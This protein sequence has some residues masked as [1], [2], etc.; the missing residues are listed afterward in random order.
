[1]ILIGSK[2]AGLRNPKLAR[3]TRDF[4][5]IVSSFSEAREWLLMHSNLLR[6]ESNQS[7]QEKTAG[8]HSGH[9]GWC[10]KSD[11]DV[12]FEFINGQRMTSDRMLM[13]FI[14]MD[15]ENPKDLPSFLYN[16][17]IPSLNTLFA[18]KSAHRFKPSVHFWKTFRDYHTMKQIGCTIPDWLQE[19]HAER[20]KESLGN[21]KKSPNL[22]T[23]KDEFFTDNVAYVYDH[24]SL[25]EIMALG[26]RP[27]YTEFLAHGQQ[28]FAS[29]SK[30][31]ACSYTTKINSVIEE[32]C[33]LALERCLIPY[34]ETN[35]SQAFKMALYKVL[36]T[37]TSGWWREFAYQ[38]GIEVFRRYPQDF[39]ENFK[40]NID[41]IR[42]Y[43]VRSS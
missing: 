39:Y 2:A 25:H 4:D 36:T 16:V 15:E 38:N 7:I 34:P 14:H 5:F 19:F 28:V 27:A 26:D 37:I 24:D 29:R 31:E 3:P 43:R 18:I 12:I 32:V 21:I 40:K 13:N 30:F 9:Q 33:V 1:M 20:Q 22:K 23:T 11:D 41:R 42:P 35:P 17:R 10:F 8:W 6:R